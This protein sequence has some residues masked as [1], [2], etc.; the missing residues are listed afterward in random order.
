MTRRGAQTKRW[1]CAAPRG[2]WLRASL[3]CRRARSGLRRAP[4]TSRA[5]IA[6]RRGALA[7][8]RRRSPTTEVRP[9][10]NNAP[11]AL[12]SSAIPSAHE[13]WTVGKPLRMG[14]VR[15]V[16]GEL[17]AGCAHFDGSGEY[18]RRCEARKAILLMIVILLS[19]ELLASRTHVHARARQSAPGV[20]RVRESLELRLGDGV[21]VADVRVAEAPDDTDRAEESGEPLRAHRRATIRVHRQGNVPGPDLVGRCRQARRRGVLDGSALDASLLALAERREN[22]VERA[23]GGE[24]H[25]SGQER[26]I[27]VLRRLVDELV[28]GWYRGRR[29]RRPMNAHPDRR[30]L[31]GPRCPCPVP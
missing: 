22:A 21:V 14:G 4:A 10:G 29:R 31:A 24:V 5:A 16:Q 25:A 18:V 30:S 2:R 12:N 13:R 6:R 8:R 17:P 7:P 9:R 23:D 20:R 1:T 28:A 15:C 11:S 3:Y 19:E 27:D 26:R